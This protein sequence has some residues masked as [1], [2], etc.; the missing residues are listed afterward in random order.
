MSD[1]ER[2]NKIRR[3]F[4]EIAGS[5]DL[6]NHLLSLGSD[7][8]WRKKAAKAINPQPGEEILDMCCGTGA[9]ANAFVKEQTELKRIVGCDFSE[10]MI[11][12]AR[13]KQEELVEKGEPGF[14]NIQWRQVDCLATGFADNSFDVVSC[15]F[16]LRNM[17]DLDA[18]LTE[19]RRVLKEN[20]RV[21]ILE[22][23]LP[24]NGLMRWGYLFYFKFVL[25]LL[26][27]LI[28]GRFGAYRYLVNTVRKW[29]REVDVAGELKQ[30]GFGDVQTL[31]LSLGI[32]K[33]YMAISPPSS[34][35]R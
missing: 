7:I 16:G 9:L 31:P 11:G 33:V 32:A 26:G 18:A 34:V 29:D 22:F 17:V 2:S 4:S 14:K 3:M 12:L 35:I 1:Q 20:G 13:E 23:S 15:A 8:R 6:A 5:Y 19:M 10:T 30:A 21:C 28:S 24:G 25:P 27:G